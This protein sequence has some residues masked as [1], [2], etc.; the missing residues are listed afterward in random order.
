M[1]AARQRNPHHAAT[2]PVMDSQP[3]S[4]LDA[5]LDDFSWL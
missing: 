5:Q 1:P 3:V 2:M 4:K